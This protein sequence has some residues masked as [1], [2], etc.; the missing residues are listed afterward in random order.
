MLQAV[1]GCNLIMCETVKL[2]VKS[3][4]TSFLG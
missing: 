3:S 2:T 1:I 4:Q